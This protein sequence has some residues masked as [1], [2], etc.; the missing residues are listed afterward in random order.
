MDVSGS[1]DC[2]PL[3]TSVLRSDQVLYIVQLV[4]RFIGP[5]LENTSRDRSAYHNTR[6]AVLLG[7][8]LC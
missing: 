3:Q 4:S 5:K 1:Q 8:G 2:P 6:L 7:T